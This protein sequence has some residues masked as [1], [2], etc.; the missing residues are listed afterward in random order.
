MN[1]GGCDTA[2][3]TAGNVPSCFPTEEKS[4]DIAAPLKLGEFNR[5]GSPARRIMTSIT[6]EVL[7]ALAHQVE[8][9]EQTE[10]E[11][12]HR[13]IRAYTRILAVREPA[14]FRRRACEYGDETGY[15]DGFYLPKMQCRNYTGPRL[16][17]IYEGDY[18]TIPTS[19][20]FDHDWKAVTS[21]LGLYISPAGECWGRETAGTGEFGSFPAYP[22]DCSVEI[23]FHWRELAEDEL[24][25]EGLREAEERLRE[26]AFPHVAALLER[27]GG[28]K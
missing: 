23:E 4:P 18:S 16:F 2:S 3:E 11:H 7:E 27:K 8:E 19:T 10:R 24:P 14:K 15:C 6:I 9:Q 20:G 1:E 26:A 22:G 25:I 28:T 12:L 13:L 21:D 5:R 17:S